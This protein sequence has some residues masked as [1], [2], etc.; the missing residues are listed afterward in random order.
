MQLHWKEC[1][2]VNTSQRKWQKCVKIFKWIE[3][4]C[5]HF[6]RKQR[7]CFAGCIANGPLVNLMFACASVPLFCSS[8]LS[9][10]NVIYCFAVNADT[11]WYRI[12]IGRALVN[13]GNF[14]RRVV[15]C[16]GVF[17]LW[18]I[19]ARICYSNDF[20][21]LLFERVFTPISNAAAVLCVAPWR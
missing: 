15:I 20:F 11:S 9:S 7:K 13:Q 8:I 4:I 21:T 10:W 5:F 12:R 3:N 19:S 6:I 1:S 17:L 14:G 18:Q 2:K 16:S